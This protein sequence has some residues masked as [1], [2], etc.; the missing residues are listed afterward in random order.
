M[1]KTE[2][3]IN[4]S[5]L[6]RILFFFAS[7][8]IAQDFTWVNGNGATS[9]QGIYGTI[10]FPSTQNRPGS[11]E[12]GA[13]WTDLNGNLWL[14][15]GRGFSSNSTIDYL[16][17]LWKYD[18]QTNQ[19]VWMMGINSVA[20]P[21]YTPTYGILLNSGAAN[22]PGGRAGASAWVDAQGNLWLFGGYGYAT[23]GL[24]SLNDVWKFNITTNQWTWMGGSNTKDAQGNFGTLGVTAPSNQPGARTYPCTWSDNSGNFWI[25]GGI[26]RTAAST[27]TVLTELWKFNPTINQWTWV[28]DGNTFNTGLQVLGTQGIAAPAN[29]PGRIHGASCWSD[30]GQFWLFGGTPSSVS[31][32]SGSY[33]NQLW[34]YNISSNQWVWVSG[35]GIGY[36]NSGTYGTL[37]TPSSNNMPG[38]RQYAVTWRDNNNNFRMAGGYGLDANNVH[39]YLNDVWVFNPAQ[40]Q[41]TWVKGSNAINQFGTYG[42][43]GQS[44][45]LNMPGG[46]QKGNVWKDNQGNIWLHGG[47][48]YGLTGTPGNLCDLWRYTGNSVQPVDIAQQHSEHLQLY[49]N[50]FNK[51]INLSGINSDVFKIEIYNTSGNLM[52]GKTLQNVSTNY[53]LDF[54]ELGFNSGIYLLKFYTSQSY[55][56]QKLFFKKE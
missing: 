28:R 46:R 44:S 31:G 12:G 29:T 32:S 4:Q 22:I 52:F 5:F 26:H 19:W 30:G 43:M 7:Y 24:G 1:S 10:T 27:A 21:N 6:F 17:D 36:N 18:I 38:S 42:T 53:Q 37:N 13:T 20:S 25:Y 23:D 50:P 45:A 33:L 15:G 41:W 48:G 55:S 35:N 34:K 14:F 39:G 16:N 49:P 8:S 9:Q 40:L 11:R 3:Q 2:I 51:T 56:L 54:D 47:D